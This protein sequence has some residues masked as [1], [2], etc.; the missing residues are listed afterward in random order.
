[1]KTKSEQIAV[2][3]RSS[4][5]QTEVKVGML[6]SAEELEAMKHGNGWEIQSVLGTFLC[7]VNKE[8][9]YIKAQ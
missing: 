1:M 8:G 9:R 3:T 6:N 7:K 4:G 5:H 2:W